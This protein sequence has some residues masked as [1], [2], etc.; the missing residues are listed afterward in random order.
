MAELTRSR[1][2]SSGK[3]ENDP[4]GQNH[5]KWF[6]RLSRSRTPYCLIYTGKIG[7]AKLWSKNLFL[8]LLHR[9]IK[10]EVANTF[11]I[12]LSITDFV[13]QNISKKINSIFES[14]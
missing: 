9:K 1:T 7:F 2:P 12:A 4:S 5:E 3:V 13:V 8:L 6:F 11:F 10:L 14:V